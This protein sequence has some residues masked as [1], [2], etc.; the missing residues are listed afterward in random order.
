MIIQFFLTAML[1][2]ISHALSGNLHIHSSHLTSLSVYNKARVQ[3]NDVSFSFSY[4]YTE[5]IFMFLLPPSKTRHANHSWAYF[6]FIYRVLLNNIHV[7]IVHVQPFCSWDAVSL[8]CLTLF[9][10]LS[11][12]LKNTIQNKT[13][14]I[15]CNGFRNRV[16]LFY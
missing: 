14:I 13:K 10:V 6:Y 8:H 4:L 12:F 1:G 2:L 9:S 5:N 3:G 16:L 15:F 11:R 7:N